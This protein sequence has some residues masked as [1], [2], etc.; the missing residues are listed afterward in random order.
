MLLGVWLKV[1]L[2]R[3]GLHID[4]VGLYCP[5]PAVSRRQGGIC[6]CIRIPVMVF[7]L[8]W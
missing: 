1:V 7:D 4:G 6:A 2:G 5:W 3:T 8:Y